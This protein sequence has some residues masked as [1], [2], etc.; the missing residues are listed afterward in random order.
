MGPKKDRRTYKH[1]TKACRWFFRVC[2]LAWF[3]LFKRSV[4][5]CGQILNMGGGCRE[6]ERLRIESKNPNPKMPLVRYVGGTWRVGGILA[7]SR[8]FGDAYL[9][10]SGQ[11]EGI[12]AGSDG[13]S[14]GF[15]VVADP[16]VTLTQLTSKPACI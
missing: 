5:N 7:L 8:A 9:K 6:R 4:D 10:G 11:F 14:S 16:T 13:Y 1:N 12:S 15:G 3:V 2:A